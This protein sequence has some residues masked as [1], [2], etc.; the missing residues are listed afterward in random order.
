M[1]MEKTQNAEQI[2]V[3]K[4]CLLIVEHIDHLVEY[5]ENTKKRSGYHSRF[6]EHLLHHEEKFVYLGKSKNLIEGM[7]VYREHVVPCAYMM[8]ELERLIKEKRYS[9]EELACALQK[10]W[11]IAHITKEEVD[12][13]NYKLKLKSTMPAGWDFM[14]S[15]PENRLKLAGIQLIYPV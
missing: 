9:K 6:F 14:T 1:L 4:T 3:F 15:Y 5:E 12:Y 7:Q 8:S 10:N 13:L 2:L 11:K